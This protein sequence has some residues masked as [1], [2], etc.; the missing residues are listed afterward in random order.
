MKLFVKKQSPACWRVTIDNPPL[1]LFDQEVCDELKVLIDEL[2]KDDEV[3][4]VVFDSADPEYFISHLDVV[5]APD[6]DLS[7]GPTGLAVWPDFAVRIEKAP[8]ITVGLLRGRARGVGSE[9]LQALDVRFASREKAILS[10]IEV[11]TGLIPGGGGMERLPLLI[12][13]A[14]A[15]EVI[16]GADDY[17]ADTAEKYGWV[18]R[19]IPDAELDEFVD[20]FAKRVASFNKKAIAT[21]KQLINERTHVA[22]VADLAA[23]QN[24][25]FGLLASPEAQERIGNLLNNGLQQRGDMENRLGYHLGV[26]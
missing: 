9:F 25:F 20:R 1:N 26:L 18:N 24:I 11:G 21:A 3:K 2:E 10:Q 7:P 17:D 22:Q 6:M 15:I 4:V 16:L 13:R 12:G 8:F 23:T 5:R 14:R 19:S